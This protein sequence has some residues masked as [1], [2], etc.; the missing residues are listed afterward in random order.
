MNTS[1]D[2][3]ISSEFAQIKFQQLEQ[4]HNDNILVFARDKILANLA[5]KLRPEFGKVLISSELK[6]CQKLIGKITNENMDQKHGIDLIL[7]EYDQAT[8]KII[9]IVS[10]RSSAP[11]TCNCPLIPIIVLMGDNSEMDSGENVKILSKVNK[12]IKFPAPT[13]DVLLAMI[14]ILHT[15]RQLEVTFK[16]LRKQKALSSKYPYLPIFEASPMRGKTKTEFESIHSEGSFLSEMEH[17]IEELDE[18]TE[19]SSLLPMVLK[20][21]RKLNPQLNNRFKMEEMLKNSSQYQEEEEKD[22]EL[23]ERQA[24][25][26]WR[27]KSYRMLE[28]KKASRDEFDPVQKEDSKSDKVGRS[29]ISFILA[30]HRNNQSAATTASRLQ[31]NSNVPAIDEFNMNEEFDELSE[32]TVADDENS[33]IAFLDNLNESNELESYEPMQRC[34]E[35]LTSEFRP[36]WDDSI[37]ILNLK[38]TEGKSRT[39]SPQ[40]NRPKTP[41]FSH[42]HD[43]SPFVSKNP[44]K[45]QRP[46]TVGGLDKKPAESYWKVLAIGIDG[47]KDTKSKDSM[48]LGRNISFN[49]LMSRQ[50]STKSMHS[51][52]KFG[53]SPSRKGSFFKKFGKDVKQTSP[54]KAGLPTIY[55]VD[56]NDNFN[57]IESK[58]PFTSSSPKNSPYIPPP[59]NRKASGV[60]FS[61]LVSSTQKE[62]T[63]AKAERKIIELAKEVPPDLQVSKLIE[64]DFSNRKI[65]LGEKDMLEKA[66]VLEKE[67]DLENAALLYSRAGAHSK[68]PQLAKMLLGNLRYNSGKI[69]ASLKFYNLAIKLLGER[70]ENQ[71]HLEDEFIAYYNRS[72][73][74]FRLGDDESGL[75]DIE[76]STSINPGHIEARALMSLAKRR[77]GRFYNAIE[78]ALVNQ[79]QRLEKQR[80]EAK[81][82][83]AK[84]KSVLRD[85]I[86]TSI[87]QSKRISVRHSRSTKP[88]LSRRETEMSMLS[89]AGHRTSD[90]G[91]LTRLMQ[92]LEVRQENNRVLGFQTRGF[93]VDVDEPVCKNGLKDKIREGRKLMKG[94]LDELEGGDNE[95]GALKIFRM[96]NGMKSRLFDDI[97]I[98]PSEL[99]S[100]LLVEPGHRD[101]TQI[102]VICTTLRL[103]PFLRGLSESI[104]TDLANAVEYRALTTKDILFSQNKESCAVCFLLNGKIQIR[105]ESQGTGNLSS[106]HIGDVPE[107]SVFGHTDFLF[108]HKNPYIMKHLEDCLNNDHP[109]LAY[110]SEERS[111]LL[112]SSNNNPNNTGN[113][114]AI[115]EKAENDINYLP[116]LTGDIA[117]RSLAP[118]MFKS[119]Y[120][121]SMVELL[122]IGEKAFERLLLQPAISEFQRRLEIVRACGIFKD[123]RRS[124]HV[125]LARMGVIRNIKR[126]EI[127]LDQGS[128]PNFLYL[129]L[130]GICK[131]YKQPNRT[132]MLVQKLKIAQE[133]AERHDL[134][135]VFH[136][137]LRNA[138]T[139]NEKTETKSK[140]HFKT[141]DSDAFKRRPSRGSFAVD[142]NS[143]TRTLNSGNLN[144]INCFKDLDL[145]LPSAL[146]APKRKLTDSEKAR[147]QLQE[148]IHKLEGLIQRAKMQDAREMNSHRFHST[149]SLN[150]GFNTTDTDEYYDEKDFSRMPQADK[151]KAEITTLQWPKFFGEACILDPENGLSR[152]SIVADTA[153]D[154]FMIHKTQIQTFAVNDK[155][156]ERVKAKATLYPIDPDI[157]V[158]LFRQK[159]WQEY[160]S[161]ILDAVPKDRWPKKNVGV[162]PFLIC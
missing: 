147:Q 40:R 65:N 110:S 45:L 155:F 132:E 69:M 1:A 95:G 88:P 97:F 73:I 151:K 29:N 122:M 79:M 89:G 145:G 99:Q 43:I 114:E 113:L 41:D 121:Q 160:R 22:K 92:S 80:L 83:E 143:P 102:E 38:N 26:E 100:S 13:R 156:L 63:P 18:Y 153:C 67:G 148:E 72:I 28:V 62:I 4:A 71:R 87:S 86:R 7:A 57:M 146:D 94:E 58:M 105:M 59:L 136:H 27:E 5:R 150:S 157:A 14:E 128:K 48:S 15:R 77:M 2:V 52:G 117:D 161:E 49:G 24:M 19:C 12:I 126:N 127:I 76:K 135:Y 54:S 31:V 119:Y 44:P 68:D 158:S 115:P 129:I 137:K 39:Q 74:N 90:I 53:K 70:K 81:A 103:F 8:I 140:T 10:K 125:R 134:K 141:S 37:N 50:A 111:S 78:D 23:K 36:I 20:E 116:S 3:K 60:S 16:D 130:K 154:V 123:W 56:A 93:V 61:S 133:K 35:L 96:N 46:M 149:N 101:I 106:F 21:E 104:L 84:K 32:N 42:T 64:I 120:I 159:G 11:D 47:N 51:T 66:M 9:D 107:F 162:E 142:P 75:S 139:K 124:D 108:R 33:G 152:G 34:E 25:Q 55:S 91:A 109:S 85:S 82:E 30:E 17:K 131:V 6:D 118:G 112:E 138:L 98:K 144:T